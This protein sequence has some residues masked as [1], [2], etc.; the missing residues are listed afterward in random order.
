MD[1]LL[2]SFLFDLPQG[3]DPQHLFLTFPNYFIKVLCD[4]SVIINHN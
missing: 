3:F 2:S 4:R 1:S